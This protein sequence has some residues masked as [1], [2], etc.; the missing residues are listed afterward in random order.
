MLT[1]FLDDSMP[2]LKSLFMCQ[3]FNFPN[4]A[5]YRCWAEKM[6]CEMSVEFLVTQI[7]KFPR[8]VS[9]EKSGTNIS[10]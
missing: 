6:S 7:E 4:Q 9:A 2:G 10:N 5:G 8:W 1:P 3:A